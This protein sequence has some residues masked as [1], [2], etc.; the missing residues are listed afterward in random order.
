LV[1]TKQ[2]L[3][4]RAYGPGG[5]TARPERNHD[6]AFRRRRGRQQLLRSHV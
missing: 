6:A 2:R 3:E 1:L 5:A 4:L